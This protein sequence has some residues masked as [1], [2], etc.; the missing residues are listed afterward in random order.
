MGFCSRSVPVLFLEVVLLTVAHV[1]HQLHLAGKSLL[2]LCAPVA[3]L[4]LP[5]ML[6]NLPECGVVDVLHGLLGL[7]GALLAAGVAAAVGAAGRRRRGTGTTRLKSGM[8]S[9]L[10]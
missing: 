1:V 9:L 2:A 7:P 6:L 3:V 8:V 4:L 10:L 5:L